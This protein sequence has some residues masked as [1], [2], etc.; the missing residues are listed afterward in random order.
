MRAEEFIAEAGRPYTGAEYIESLRDG[1]EVYMNGERVADIPSHPAFRNSVRS[2]ARLYDA[3]HAESTKD[4]LTRPI[5]GGGYTFRYF[6]PSASKEELIASQQ[7]IATWS[8]LNYGWMGRTPDFKA[9]WTN[10]LG[11]NSQFYGPYAENAR[12]WYKRSMT[13]PFLNHSIVNPPIDRHLP[14]AETKD[15]FIS[16]EKETDAGIIVSGAKVVATSAAMTHYN[17]IGQ[18]SKTA[19]DD[20]DMALMFIAPTNAPGV[21]LFSRVSYEQAATSPFDYPL[22]SRF[23]ENDAIIVLDK[24]F[25]PWEDVLIYRDPKRVLSWYPSSGSQNGFLFQ[26]CTRFAVKL[27]FLCGALS[28]SL[29]CT[30]G[31]EL[32][33]NQV[34]L[35][36]A[37]AWRN[38]FWSLSHMMANKPDPFVDGYVLPNGQAAISYRVFAPEAYPR[39]K[40]LIQKAMTSA[41]IYL[42]SSVKDLDNP[43]SAPYL[44]KYVRG[45]HGIDYKSRIKTLKLLWDAV[46]TE[47]GGRHELYE[48]NYAGAWEDIRAQTLMTAQRSHDLEKLE[49]MVDKCL[50]E[51]DE[52]GWTDA[53]WR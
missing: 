48:R 19:T 1:R 25:V 32:R 49:S 34:L 23:D 27:D 20:L 4:L 37:L 44:A 11:I 53:A 17:F 46:G 36:E 7:A 41:L 9:G 2:I 6:L 18:N 22:S 5:E 13:V 51:Y 42:P 3:M 21:K 16:V 47:F 28:K 35:G 43:D 31:D 38:L 15:V 45:S 30:G 39:M 29:H 12:A 52:S 50:S 8:R 40:E 33:S 24:V 14:V 10:T 26:G